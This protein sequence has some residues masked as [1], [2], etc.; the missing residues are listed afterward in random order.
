MEQSFKGHWRIQGP[1]DL[2]ET[3]YGIEFKDGF[4]YVNWKTLGE[5]ET[6]IALDQIGHDPRGFQI[7]EIVEADSP[8]GNKGPEIVEADSKVPEITESLGVPKKPARKPRK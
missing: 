7:V 5:S 2:N 6:R 1:K 4:A 3:L 8:Y